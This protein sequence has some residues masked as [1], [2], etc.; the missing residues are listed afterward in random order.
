MYKIDSKVDKP[1]TSYLLNEVKRMMRDGVKLHDL[2]SMLSKYNSEANTYANYLRDNYGIDN[3]NSSK[4][5][6]GFM[7]E[8]SS[9]EVYDIAKVDG[10][11]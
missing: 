1:D 6:V 11:W 5:I 10:K 3:P 2:D 7:V 4:Q 9:A 8:H